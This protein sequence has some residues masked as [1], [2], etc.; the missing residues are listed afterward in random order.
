VLILYVK[1]VYNVIAKKINVVVKIIINV[2]YV[3][4]INKYSS[5]YDTINIL[6]LYILSN[7]II[8]MIKLLLNFKIILVIIK[9]MIMYKLHL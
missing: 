2:S 6:F 7:T 4:N 9:L 8:I 5:F 3:N 1:N